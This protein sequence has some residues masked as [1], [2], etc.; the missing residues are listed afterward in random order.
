MPVACA[1]ATGVGLSSTLAPVIVEV[2]RRIAH[3]PKEVD[4][5]PVRAGHPERSRE[6]RQAGAR[7]AVNS[8]CWDQSDRGAAVG[9]VRADGLAVA[10]SGAKVFTIASASPASSAAW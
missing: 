7:G 5:R 4:G 3:R 2:Q 8:W 1:N 6:H 9:G 10:P